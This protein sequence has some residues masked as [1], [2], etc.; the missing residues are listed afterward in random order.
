MTEN[1]PMV[2]PSIVRIDRSL[3]TPIDESAILRISMSGILIFDS[4]LTIYDLPCCPEKAWERAD[5]ATVRAKSRNLH[6]ARSAS[7]QK[8]EIIN[9]NS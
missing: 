7:V 8:S 2:M 3:F 1:T 4:R 5:P 9:R 6:L